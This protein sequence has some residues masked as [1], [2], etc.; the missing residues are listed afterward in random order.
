MWK[1]LGLI[2]STRNKLKKQRS[3]DRGNIKEEKETGKY[4]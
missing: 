2:L 1:V 3:N 4:R